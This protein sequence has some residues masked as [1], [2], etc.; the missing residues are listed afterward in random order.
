MFHR[1]LLVVQNT[2]IILNNVNM[3]VRFGVAKGWR[4]KLDYVLRIEW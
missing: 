3:V 1:I 4:K 2:V